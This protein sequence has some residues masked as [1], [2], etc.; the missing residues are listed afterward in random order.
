MKT[1]F[2]LELLLRSTLLLLCG[3]FLLLFL[4]RAW[5]S[6]RHRFILFVFL[7]LAVLPGL[8]ILVPQVPLRSWHRDAPSKAFVTAMEIPSHI[9]PVTAHGGIDWLFAC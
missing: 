6:L 7:G 3:E 9:G 4:R 5:P 1:A 2:W 8:L